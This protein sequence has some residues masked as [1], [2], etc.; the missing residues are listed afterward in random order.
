V[1]KSSTLRFWPAAFIALS[2]IFVHV[3]THYLY[4]GWWQIFRI[5]RPARQRQRPIH[6]RPCHGQ[7]N[8]SSVGLYKNVG[9]LAGCSTVPLVMRSN[10]TTRARSPRA[11][12]RGHVRKASVIRAATDQLCRA[13]HLEGWL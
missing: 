3:L 5:F 1:K 12:Q 7:G 10:R 9:H 8:L 6:R 2:Y 13:L 11:T 4:G